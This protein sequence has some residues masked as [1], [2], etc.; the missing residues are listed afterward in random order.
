M[1]FIKGLF[2]A[3][4]T[5]GSNNVRQLTY[6]DCAERA[7]LVLLALEVMRQYPDYREATQKYAKRTIAFG[8]Y[9]QYRIGGTDLY[10]FMYFLVGDK[11]AQDKLKDPE[12]AERIKKTLNIPLQQINKYL[13]ELSTGAIPR[14]SFS[15][16]AKV[17][18][19]LKITNPD[20]RALRRYIAN[21]A[22]LSF[23]DRQ[24]VTTRLLLA[25]RA[26]LRSSDLI[27]DIE[28]WAA[29][30]NLEKQIPVDPEPTVSTPDVSTSPADIALYRYLV[31]SENMASTRR[32]LD[33]AK[34]GKAVSSE[35][36]RAYL[37]II[38]MIDD[39]VAAGPA[40]VQNLKALHKRSKKR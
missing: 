24:I 22:K 21:F 3:R 6:T 1:D 12:A 2:E 16:L 10:N 9:Q 40:H 36:L 31:G 25:A 14:N 30:K 5:Q 27:D 8:Q 4:M 15:V 37:P 38:E 39:I 34:N 29:D 19:G 20:Y 13:R 23:N 26:K 28:K 11:E 7:Y 32:F 35:M 18:A 17:E 33:H